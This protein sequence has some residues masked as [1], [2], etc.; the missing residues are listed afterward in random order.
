MSVTPAIYATLEDIE[1]RHPR[2]LIVLAADEQTGVQDNHR[3]NLALEDASSEV[4]SVLKGRYT[5][6]DLSR[7]DA[8]SLGALRMFTIDVA[9]YKVALAFSRS[10][11]RI[12]ERY[13]AAIKRLEAIVAG[14]GALSFDDS[15]ADEGSGA[16]SGTVSPNEVIIDAPERIFT[17]ERMRG[18]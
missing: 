10:N 8:D 1:A 2:E 7:L 5:N 3:I 12:E 15:A 11:E 14:K 17:R 16:G 18:L 13:K 9:L 6:D 4:R